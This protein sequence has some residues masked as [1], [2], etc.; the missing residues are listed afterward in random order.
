MS[1]TTAVGNEWRFRVADAQ[2]SDIAIKR[3]KKKKKHKIHSLVSAYRLR[4]H[5]LSVLALKVSQRYIPGVGKDPRMSCNYP[6]IDLDRPR[7][8]SFA[9]A[10]FQTIP[11]EGGTTLQSVGEAQSADL[12]PGAARQAIT[13]P[14]ERQLL[15]LTMFA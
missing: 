5:D 4:Y 2:S 10:S 14:F 3:T 8:V 11:S 1:G 15:S 13:I 9:L 12:L 6:R 7:R